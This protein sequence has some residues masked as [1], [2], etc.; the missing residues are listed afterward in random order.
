MNPAFDDLLS[1]PLF[2]DHHRAV[3]QTARQKLSA[4]AF[5]KVE[6]T[7]IAALRQSTKLLGDAG[8]L[9]HTV[10]MSGAESRLTELCLVREATAWHSIIGDLALVMQ[11]LG[12]LS[13]QLGGSDRL[14]SDLL[15]SVADGTKVAAFALTEPEAGSDVAA[16]TT[17]A[18]PKDGGYLLNGYKHL[19]SNAGAADFYT[20]FAKLP[21]ASR[22]GITAF[23]VPADSEGLSIEETPPIS[24]HPLGSIT[25]NNVF[26]P[27][28]HRLGDE[29]GGLKLALMTLARCRPTV[30]AAACGFARRALEESM[31][32]VQNRSAFGGKLSDLQ[33]VQSL[34]SHSVAELDAARLLTYRCTVAFD[35]KPDARHDRASS[36]A[37]WYATEAAQRIIDRS[38][39]LAG[40]RAVL[41]GDL[42]AELYQAIR[43]LRIYEGASEVQQVVI[44]RGLFGE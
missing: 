10:T 12:S 18:T 33:L 13:I 21:G 7:G 36:I 34:I 24:P 30:A 25:F 4:I 35:A 15:P 3:L 20:V 11:A 27:T 19:I 26:V 16:L 5:P 44:A 17:E 43:P 31:Q 2:S 42:L 41:Q 40:G 1:L 39:Q 28:K 32:R 6:G 38:V 9:R 8:L 14:K 29:G 22:K 37:K 23:F